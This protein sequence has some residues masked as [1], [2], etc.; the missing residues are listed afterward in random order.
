VSSRALLIFKPDAAHRLAVRSAI[1]SWL[2]QRDDLRVLGLTW[3]KAPPE[4]I[5]SHYD[6]LRDR[7]FFPWL[8]DFMT[9]LPVIVGAVETEDL[10][11]VRYDL[12]ETQ[13]QKSRPGSVRERY[14]IYGG[15]NCLHLSD[16]PETGAKE[17]ELWSQHVNL[18]GGVQA[19]GLDGGGD[20]VDLTYQLRS[21]AAQYSAGIH[22]ELAGDAIAGLL[23][24]ETDL[25]EADFAAFRRIILGAFE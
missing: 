23:E 2:D 9:A 12:G 3:F 16:A 10:E 20:R 15:V 18:T 11:K 22:K 21:L 4:L 5:E 1:W 6:F 13:I 14:G 7:P 19:D 8:V 24:E 25:G 17:T